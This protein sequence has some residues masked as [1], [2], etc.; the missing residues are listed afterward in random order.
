MHQPILKSNI[1]NKGQ[2]RKDFSS[3][4]HG[5]LQECLV[6]CGINKTRNKDILFANPYSFYKMKLEISVTDTWKKRM[7]S[8]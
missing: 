2:D 6:D 3:W 8:K 1:K 5:H 4:N 7:K